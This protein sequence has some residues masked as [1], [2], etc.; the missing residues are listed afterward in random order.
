MSSKRNLM[1]VWDPHTMKQRE[2]LQCYTP[3]SFSLYTYYHLKPERKKTHFL[4]TQKK[5]K[6]TFSAK[7]VLWCLELLE[8]I[9]GTF[10]VILF[11]LF[12]ILCLFFLMIVG[13]LGAT[14]PA[15]F[16]FFLFG[17]FISICIF[18]LRSLLFFFSFYSG[19][20]ED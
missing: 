13:F 6:K 17:C 15:S 14:M 10:S 20:R 11:Y 3:L 1:G 18:S 16:F 5:K 9:Q 8:K 2:C 4:C 12:F 7:E 19:Y